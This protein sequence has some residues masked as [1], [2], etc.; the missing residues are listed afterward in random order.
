MAHRRA[1]GAWAGLALAAIVLGLGGVVT[2]GEEKLASGPP[3]GGGT[4]PF[5]VLDVTGPAAGQSLCYV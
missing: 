1:A 3:V 2:A 4:P 5:Q